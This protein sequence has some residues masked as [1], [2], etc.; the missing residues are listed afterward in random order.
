MSVTGEHHAVWQF[1]NNMESEMSIGAISNNNCSAAQLSQLSGTSQSSSSSATNSVDGVPAPPS[2][3]GGLVDA[4]SKALAQIGIT[5]P[6]STTSTDTSTSATTSTEDPAQAM[7]AFMQTLMAA[8]HAQG[9]QA[10]GTQSAATGDGDSSG[11]STAAVS[12]HGHHHHGGGG[13]GKVEADLQSL[14]QSLSTSTSDTSSSATSTSGTDATASVTGSSNSPQANLQQS[15]QNLVGAL[16]GSSGSSVTLSNFLQTLSN[17][18]QGAGNSGN[19]V[20][21]KV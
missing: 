6:S 3:G 12:G 9:A 19:V 2:P 17:D 4:I 13:K 5:D 7:T 14:I 1:P 20:N 16:G 10:N 18:M 21:T 15:F 8:L 11:S